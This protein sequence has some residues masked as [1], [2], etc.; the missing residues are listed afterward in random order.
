[1]EY[2]IRVRGHLDPTWSDWFDSLTI[3]NEVNGE[4][5]L[6]GRIADQAALYGVLAKLRDL[7]VPLIALR[8]EEDA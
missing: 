4:A 8:H 6:A 3:T 1:M 7:G 5:V 2:R